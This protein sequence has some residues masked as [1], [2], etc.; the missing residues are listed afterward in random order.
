MKYGI[1]FEGT[2]LKCANCGHVVSV[3]GSLEKN[4]CEECGAPL[5]PLAIGS[6]EELKADFKKQLLVTLKDI[7]VENHTDSFLEILKNYTK[8]NE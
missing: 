2:N 8:E 5:S 4:Y 6:F 7:A 3:N 1:E